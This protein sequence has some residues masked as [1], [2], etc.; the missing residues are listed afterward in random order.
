MRRPF[1][2]G[3]IR[4]NDV[5]RNNL[6]CLEWELSAEELAQ[7]TEPCPITLGFPHEFLARRGM[8]YATL[9]LAKRSTKLTIIVRY[10]VL[11]SYKR[12]AIYP[13]KEENDMDQTK[14][15]RVYRVD[16]FIVPTEARDEFMAK[17]QPTHALLKTQP[18]FIQDFV[19][20]QSAGPGKFNFVTLVEWENEAAM[21]QA[22]TA[23]ST[24]HQQMNFEPQELFARLNIEADLANY[25]Q[26]KI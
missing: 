23:I 8:K 14:S 25:H 20:E 7:L 15:N 24:L 9:F 18:G 10:N 5:S 19:L 1:P 11:C 6:A 21:A 17:V 3:I 12:F 2:P 22:R 13:T 4:S 26:L 16:K